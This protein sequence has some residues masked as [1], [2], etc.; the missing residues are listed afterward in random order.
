MRAAWWLCARLLRCALGPC[1]LITSDML[2]FRHAAHG[3]LRV[4]PGRALYPR[5]SLAVQVRSAHGPPSPILMGTTPIWMAVCRERGGL[6]RSAFS[7]VHAG[8]RLPRAGSLGPMP[9]QGPPHSAVSATNVMHTLWRGVG[10]TVVCIILCCLL[11]L[12]CLPPRGGS[13][14][15]TAVFAL[16]FC[17]RT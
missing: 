17:V 11:R 4:G 9:A 1:P 16:V 5:Q 14:N 3:H 8:L 10:G 12:G 6:M 2:S 7:F 15:S 13:R